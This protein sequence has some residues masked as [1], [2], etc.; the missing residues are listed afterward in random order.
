MV[1][2]IAWL[3]DTH[4]SDVN[5]YFWLSSANWIAASAASRGIEAIIHTGDFQD[6]TK[7][8]AHASQ[9]GTLPFYPTIGN[10][11]YDGDALNDARLTTAFDAAFP[12]EGLHGIQ[13]AYAA[14]SAANYWAM[15][16]IDGVTY[17]ILVLEF[18]PRD[19]VLAWAATVLAA[20]PLLPF[21]IATHSYLWHDSGIDTAG[22]PNNPHDDAYRLTDCNDGTEIYNAIVATHANVRMVLSGHHYFSYYGYGNKLAYY[23]LVT[24][25]GQ[26]VHQFGSGFHQWYHNLGGSP[27]VTEISFDH[28]SNSL[29]TWCWSPTLNIALPGGSRHGTLV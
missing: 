16:A 28:G 10:H 9:L 17:G 24:H 14:G 20:N 27:F 29:A 18:G 6:L 8:A 19:A 5:P 7:A 21:I 13:A 22:S 3:S 1:A 25:A 12:V 26:L 11:D 2:R 4:E 15:R 23:P